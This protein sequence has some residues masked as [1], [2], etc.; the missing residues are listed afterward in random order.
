VRSIGT[1]A[2]ALTALALSTGCTIII[3]PKASTPTP[4]PAGGGISCADLANPATLSA[5]LFLE[6]RISRAT[7]DPDLSKS[8]SRWVETTALALASANIVT[9]QAVM[10]RLDERPVDH[11]LLG[12]WG[13]NFDDP[14][15]LLPEDVIQFYAT[16]PD[17]PMSP[18]GCATDPLVSIAEQLSNTVT[19]YPP[20]LSGRSGQSLGGPSPS[21]AL[22]IHIDDSER[23][24]AFADSACDSAHRMLSTDGNGHAAW[25]SYSDDLPSGRVVHWFITTDELIDRDTFVSRC[26]AYQGFPVKTLDLID[27]SDRA[28]YDPL[29]SAIESANAG[30]IAKLPLCAALSDTELQK[31]LS[32][33]IHAVADLLGAKVNEDV[34]KRVLSGQS[35]P[36]SP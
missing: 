14:R 23:R 5:H 32:A 11:P 33:Q 10:I 4:I 25:L 12:A 36:T 35:L 30:H 29:S 27:P 2:A 7:A 15:K 20:E 17:L 24:S 9:T 21:V 1:T 8:Y 22:F 13:C 18:I 26:T 16:Q 6:L 34:L 28:L 3:Q 31:F 19:D